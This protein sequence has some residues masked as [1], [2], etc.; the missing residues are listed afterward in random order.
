VYNLNSIT[1]NAEP[2]SL[3]DTGPVI[4]NVAGVGTNQPISFAGNSISNPTFDPTNLPH[5]YGG[6]STVSLSGSTDT[7]LMLYPRLRRWT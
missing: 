3:F 6:T 5:P 7:A 1:V 2:R 4:L